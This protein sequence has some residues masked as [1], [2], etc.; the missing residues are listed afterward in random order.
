[1]LVGVLAGEAAVAEPFG[2][3]EQ[4]EH[5]AERQAHG[6]YDQGQP[7]G[8]GMSAFNADSAEDGHQQPNSD[9]AAQG[10][11]AAPAKQFRSAVGDWWVTGLRRNRDGV[12]L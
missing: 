12:F 3:T 6:P 10:D 5:E 2:C 11:D 1:M 9:E 8:V 7:A 4:E